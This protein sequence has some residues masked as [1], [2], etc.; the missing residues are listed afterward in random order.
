MCVI[1]VDKKKNPEKDFFADKEEM[2][3]RSTGSRL[4]WL[5]EGIGRRIEKDKMELKSTG[6][7]SPHV[8]NYGTVAWAY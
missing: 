3:W 1:V 6:Q 2:L 5:L 4:I 7:K 8:S